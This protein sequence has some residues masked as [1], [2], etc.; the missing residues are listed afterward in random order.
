MKRS[1]GGGGDG[2]GY[3]AAR[4]AWGFGVAEAVVQ[5]LS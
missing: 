1:Q 3:M 5:Y 4:A 2:I